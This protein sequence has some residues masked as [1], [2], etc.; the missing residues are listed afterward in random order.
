MTPR[1]RKSHRLEQTLQD[2]ATPLF[3]LDAQR[4]VTFVSHGLAELTGFPADTFLQ[5]VCDYAPAVDPHSV[6]AVLAILAPPAE[7]WHGQT[8]ELAVFMPHRTHSPTA[9]LIRYQPLLT[10]DAKISGV[11]GSLLPIPA[12]TQSLRPSAAQ[13][14]HAE[15]AALRQTLRA[16][17]QD[18]TFVGQHPAILRALAQVEQARQHAAPVLIVGETGTGR[19]HLA[20]LIHSRGPTQ[21]RTFLPLRCRELTTHE[22]RRTFKQAA[23]AA[24]TGAVD[25]LLPG[26]LFLRDVDQ[27]AAEAQETLRELLPTG[28][29]RKAGGGTTVK[30]PAT[31]SPLLRI[32]ASTTV[33]VDHLLGRE[34]FRE[35]LFYELT[36][37]VLTLP[38]LRQRS[39]DIELLTQHFLEEL[40]RGA[41]HTLSGISPEV[42]VEF[43]KHQWPG[44]VGELERVLCEARLAARGPKLQTTDLPLRF[45]TSRD[46]Q[47]V[48]P[49]NTL[50]VE[51]LDALL[52]RTEKQAIVHALEQARQNRSRAADLLGIPR[53]RLYRRMEQLGLYFKAELD[54]T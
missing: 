1:S 46:A 50:P 47:S 18:S 3:L 16:R 33:P 54:D 17:F 34:T 7:V 26:T 4:H 22:I 44:N 45:R 11:F 8:M 14:V 39:T 35:D 12:T 51:P 53:A 36:S 6:A 27:L 28:A 30:A 42:L 43:Q 20:R 40:N 37:Q 15:L 5:Q 9:R 19:E 25:A 29:A 13:R 48:A 41:T 23:E 2:S 49:M 31:A 24:T 32:I 10:S 38:P 52:E 21:K